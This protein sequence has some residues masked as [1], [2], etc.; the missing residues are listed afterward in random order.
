MRKESDHALLSLLGDPRP[1]KAHRPLLSG[2]PERAGKKIAKQT[3][4]VNP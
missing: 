3:V 1:R 2:Q 4:G